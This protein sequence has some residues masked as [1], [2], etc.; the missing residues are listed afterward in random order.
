MISPSLLSG[1]DKGANMIDMANTVGIDVAVLGNHEF[2]FGPEILQARVGESTFRWLSG[3]TAMQGRPNFP[4][5]AD[6]TVVAVGDRKVGILGLHTPDPAQVS[7]P[8]PDVALDA[9]EADGAP[10][11]AVQRGPGADP[12]IA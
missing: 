6:A 3:N 8:G 9:P 5:V 7:S 1:I 10:S 12:V 4:G 2:D 11:A